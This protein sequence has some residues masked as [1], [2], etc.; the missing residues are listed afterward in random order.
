MRALS[1]FSRRWKADDPVQQ[2]QLGAAFS[3]VRLRTQHSLDDDPP[4]PYI[5]LESL[6]Q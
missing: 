3:A 4:P 5:F 1:L 2:P 6:I